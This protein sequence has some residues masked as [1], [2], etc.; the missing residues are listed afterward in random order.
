MDTQLLDFAGLKMC[1][2][3]TV[4]LPFRVPVVIVTAKHC[5][6]IGYSPLSQRY[7]RGLTTDTRVTR[8][9]LPCLNPKD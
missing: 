3:Y 7:Q 2:V 4:V 9:A 1:T 5:A 6:V 8:L